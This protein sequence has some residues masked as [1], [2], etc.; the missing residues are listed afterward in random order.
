MFR[1]L[2]R[3]CTGAAWLQ[4]RQTSGSI[5]N[6]ELLLS[7]QVSLA[8]VQLDVL[9]AKQQIDGDPRTN[10]LRTLLPLNQD[11]IHLIARRPS[12]D[13]LGRIR[14]VQTFTDL[15]GKRVGAW[16]GSVITANVLK[17]KSGTAY[18]VISYPD[19]NAA[20]SALAAGQVDALLAVVGQPADWVKTLDSQQY[21]LLPLNIPA[22][23]LNG[24]Y[25]PTRLLYTNFGPAISTYS[26]QRLLITR[27][28]K[29]LERRAQLL[30]YQACAKAK[31]TALQESEGMHP[32]WSDVT[33]KNAEWPVFK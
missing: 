4:Q 33:F 5:E 14:G 9:K 25:K 29:T 16:G 26:V 30:K 2:G 32:K 10:E 3:V 7:N 12:T 8:F 19:R 13:L 15:A 18:T 6:L 1:D 23:K 31:L 17:A 22:G 24:F 11:E 21:S 27:N 20:L 28:F